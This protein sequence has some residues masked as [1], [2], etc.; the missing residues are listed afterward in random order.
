MEVS[1]IQKEA[2]IE[3]QKKIKE[4]FLKFFLICMI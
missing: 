1:E 3:N 4:V 2:E